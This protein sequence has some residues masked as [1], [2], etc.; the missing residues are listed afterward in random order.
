MGPACPHP[1][2]ALILNGVNGLCSLRRAAFIVALLA[3]ALPSAYYGFT[4]AWSDFSL[5]KTNWNVMQWQEGKLALPSAVELGKARNALSNALMVTPGNPM[6]HEDL[7]YLY[8]VRATKASGIPE[9]RNAMLSQSLAY[10]RSAAVLRPMSPH[11]WANI[12]LANHYL[13]TVGPEFWDAFD[14]S[15][16]YGRNEFSVQS[17]LAEI[18]FSR[19]QELS[20]VRRKALLAMISEAPDNSRKTFA[21]I[22]ARYHRSELEL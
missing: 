16:N 8:G 3:G 10:F 13:G 21:A 15:L 4:S 12:A 18:G 6:I 5:L 17:T 7:G 14:R 20:D 11:T 9:L 22:A 1:G 2:T 19:W